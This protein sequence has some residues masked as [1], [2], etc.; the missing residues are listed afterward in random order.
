MVSA[1]IAWVARRPP[2][3]T[4]DQVAQVVRLSAR[5]IGRRATTRARASAC[6]TSTARSRCAS[7]AARPA[8]AQRRPGAGST[9]ASIGRA[10]PS[11]FERPPRRAPVRPRSTL[12]ED[13]QDVVP[14][15]ASRAG[16]RRA[17]PL[18]PALR[19]RR[20]PRPRAADEVQA[21][22]A[23]PRGHALERTPA[24]VGERHARSSTARS[25]ARGRSTSAS[26]PARAARLRRRLRADGRR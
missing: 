6:S 7:A 3:L 23:A 5:D 21:R 17:S 19:R 14:D 22:A 8:R 16:A 20:R 12:T 2:D 15:R 11:V 25:R 10:Q 13:P 18:Q 26:S 4:A 9:G 24:G 1:A